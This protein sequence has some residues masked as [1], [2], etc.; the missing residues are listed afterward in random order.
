M[1]GLGLNPEAEKRAYEMLD[2][3]QYIDDFD[4][5]GLVGV[6]EGVK[7]AAEINPYA[8]KGEEAER[9]QQ[10]IEDTLGHLGFAYCKEIKEA[11]QNPRYVS[12]TYYVASDEETA[13][14]AQELRAASM[15]NDEAGAAA[16]RELGLLFGYPETAVDYFLNGWNP[17]EEESPHSANPK[18]HSYVHSPEHAEEEYE[19][20]E[21]IIDEAFQKYCP[22]SAADF[23]GRS[24]EG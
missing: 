9:A 8:E 23:F 7:R 22:N 2:A 11:I 16:E 21:Q 20:Y 14:R 1:E 19:Q 10:S 6:G 3:E 18:Y 5:Y 4:K 15:A 12:L 13:K 17:D 24:K